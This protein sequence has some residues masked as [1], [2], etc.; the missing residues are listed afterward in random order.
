M[1]NS[2]ALVKNHCR[3]HDS[4]SLLAKSFIISLLSLSARRVLVILN[5]FPTRYCAR[6]NPTHFIRLSYSHGLR[7][8]FDCSSSE[9]LQYLQLLSLPHW[10]VCMIPL[11]CA[12]TL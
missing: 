10:S 9:M 1:S 2:S 4:H 11:L 12:C 3:R 6:C 7:L 8:I 5:R